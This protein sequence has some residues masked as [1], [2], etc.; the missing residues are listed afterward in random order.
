MQGTMPGAHRRGRPQP[1]WTTSRRGQD[2]PWKNQSEWQLE[3]RD[4]WKK[5][6]FVVWPVLGS[7]NSPLRQLFHILCSCSR[8]LGLWIDQLGDGKRCRR[9]H[10]RRRQKM[11]GRHLSQHPSQMLNIYTRQLCIAHS[12]PG[13]PNTDDSPSLGASRRLYR[14]RLN[15][16]H[17]KQGR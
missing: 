6:T 15:E 17:P 12:A 11:I 16:Y 7:S 4:K 3:D 10:E 14:T 9:R 1:G 13:T 2:S 8:F 5:S